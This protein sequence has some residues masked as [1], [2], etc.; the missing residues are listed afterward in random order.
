MELSEWEVSVGYSPDIPASFPRLAVWM[1]DDQTSWSCSIVAGIWDNCVVKLPK[2]FLPQWNEKLHF[3]ICLTEKD[4]LKLRKRFRQW[5]IE[6]GCHMSRVESLSWNWSGQFMWCYVI[7]WQPAIK[8]RISWVRWNSRSWVARSRTG[9][10]IPPPGEKGY[11]SW[12][13]WEKR[14]GTLSDGRIFVPSTNFP[15]VPSSFSEWGEIWKFNVNSRLRR[16]AF[17]NLAMTFM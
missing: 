15:S 17:P 1:R 4:C 6:T 14:C 12:R 10:S 3:F 16:N 9:Y 8:R 7:K 5:N 13:S 11:A 2:W